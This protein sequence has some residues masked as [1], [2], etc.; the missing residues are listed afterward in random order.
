MGGEG[1]ESV[2]A[3]AAVVLSYL[4]LSLSLSGG[5][6]SDT[7]LTNPRLREKLK[8]G[9]SHGGRERERERETITTPLFCRPAR[10]R[11][12]RQKCHQKVVS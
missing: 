5:G 4:F 6:N 9:V 10:V 1:A 11:A 3:A 8:G 2:V 12:G 7:R